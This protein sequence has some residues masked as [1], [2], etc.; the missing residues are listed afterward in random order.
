MANAKVLT[1]EQIARMQELWV[2]KLSPMGFFVVFEPEAG[3]HTQGR[4]DDWAELFASHE[5]LR[6]ELADTQAD[7]RALA[8]ALEG[9]NHLRS[10]TEMTYEDAYHAMFKS[11]GAPSWKRAQDALA[12]PGVVVVLAAGGS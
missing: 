2:E 7:V 12:R 6:V 3:G 8:E 11:D 10:M 5:A 4:R 9:L 1:P